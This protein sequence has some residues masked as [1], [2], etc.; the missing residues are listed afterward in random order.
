MI[1]FPG[2]FKI[3]ECFNHLKLL[4]NKKLPWT[5]INIHNSVMSIFEY[6]LWL[7]ICHKHL[8]IHVYVWRCSEA[9]P[10]YS[11]LFPIRIYLPLTHR[12]LLGLFCFMY[13]HYSND[14]HKSGSKIRLSI[15]IV[16]PHGL[17]TGK[18]WARVSRTVT[19]NVWSMSAEW[20]FVFGTV[21]ENRYVMLGLPNCKDVL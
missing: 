7:S 14:H 1:L 12:T 11:S 2:Y 19:W 3:L 10:V 16:H 4:L 8:W 17:M 18:K 20:D 9:F 21:K 6:C 5:F 15:T 13:A